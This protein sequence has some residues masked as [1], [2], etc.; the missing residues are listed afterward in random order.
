[1]NA[2]RKLWLHAGRLTRARRFHVPF[3]RRARFRIPQQIWLGSRRVS[4][5]VPDEGGI[6]SD[7]LTC[8]IDDAYGLARLPSPPCSI[9]DIGAN[10]GFFSMAARAYF[11]AAI[12]HSYEP[13]P[14]V[15]GFLRAHALQSEFTCYPEAVG[16]EDGRVRMDNGGDSNQARTSL[17]DSGGIVQISLKTALQRLGGTIDLAKIDCEGA[18]WDLFRAEDCWKQIREV[19]MEYHLWKVRDYRDVLRTFDRLDFTVR[20]HE[21]SGEFGLVWCSNNRN[22]L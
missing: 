20:R 6:T 16:A 15:L 10:V 4:L 22:P 12:I 8:V 14:R 18:E 17:A 3:T 19:R 5:R 11:P 1:M 2:L 13:N 9:L 21:S 7:F